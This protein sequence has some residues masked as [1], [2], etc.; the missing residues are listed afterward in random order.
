MNT[1]TDEQN[2]STWW[3]AKL[4]TT[5][6]TLS[7]ARITA[8][9]WSFDVTPAPNTTAT[10]IT[11][12]VANADDINQCLGIIAQTPQGADPHRPDFA[13]NVF[14]YIDWPI[15]EA[16]PYVVRELVGAVQKWEPRVTLDQL[17]VE[18]YKPSIS[19]LRITA[20]WSLAGVSERTVITVGS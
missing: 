3:T 6:P 20:Q 16:Q 8:A 5:E 14:S 4:A 12:V 13:S 2:L 1:R 17:T 10:H 11:A 19:S 15:P 18:P 9:W 7:R